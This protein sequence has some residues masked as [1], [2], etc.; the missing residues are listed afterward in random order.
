MRQLVA[1]IIVS[2][3]VLLPLTQAV[4]EQEN[5]ES[6]DMLLA[7]GEKADVSNSIVRVLVDEIFRPGAFNILAYDGRSLLF[8]QP[9]GSS[10]THINAW[11][12][13]YYYTTHPTYVIFPVQEL[14]LTTPPYESVPD[15]T[16]SCI[17]E[18]SGV[19][20]EQRLTPVLFSDDSGAIFIEYVATNNDSSPHSVGVLLFMDIYVTKTDAPPLATAS[21]YVD[22]EYG[23]GLGFDD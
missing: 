3:L 20:I 15:T 7:S 12:D 14:Q 8:V 11:I 9:N 19:S 13:G 18:Q 22:R 6:P 1:A 17:W 21:G 4:A 16:I 5:P 23:W 10:L 2:S